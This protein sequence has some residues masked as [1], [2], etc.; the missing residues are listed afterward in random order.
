MR[1]TD[2]FALNGDMRRIEYCRDAQRVAA[3]LLDV[4]EIRGFADHVNYG[5]PLDVILRHRVGLAYI[6]AGLYPVGRYFR[7][8]PAHD[9]QSQVHA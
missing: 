4:V 7:R 1:E 2:S 9:F 8:V 6:S 5:A 3:L